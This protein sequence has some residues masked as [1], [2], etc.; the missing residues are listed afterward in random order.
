SS[1]SSLYRAWS[2]SCLTELEEWEAAEVEVDW[3]MERL[4]GDGKIRLLAAN[5]Y[6]GQGR[7]DDA[8]A[9]LEAALEYWSEADADFRPAAEA[10]AL[11]AE[12]QAA[13]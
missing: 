2:A 4:P 1:G 6:A 8:I 7:T 5:L 10:R 9:E 3:L 13:G 11:L 12:L